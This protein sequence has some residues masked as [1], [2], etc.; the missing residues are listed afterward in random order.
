MQGGVRVGSAQLRRVRRASSERSLSARMLTLASTMCLLLLLLTRRLQKEQQKKKE[1]KKKPAASVAQARPRGL[2]VSGVQ[3]LAGPEAGRWWC[4]VCPEG[5]P[6]AGTASIATTTPACNNE[7]SCRG[8]G[9]AD[10]SAGV[11]A[12][13]DASTAA[14]CLQPI[15]DHAPRPACTT[16]VICACSKCALCSAIWCM[17]SACPS[18]SAAKR[19][20]GWL[21]AWSAHS[22]CSN[23]QLAARGGNGLSLKKAAAELCPHATAEAAPG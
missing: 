23:Q 13:R 11:W 21:S 22:G 10:R 4:G 16:I 2:G 1:V 19:C 8:A 14:T 18:A 15:A 9:A 12:A 17:Q 5:I 20:V 6:S 3:R 7:R